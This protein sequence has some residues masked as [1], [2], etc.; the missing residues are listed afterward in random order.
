MKNV[1]TYLLLT[2]LAMVTLVPFAYLICAALKIHMFAALFLP[3][4]HEEAH[5]LDDEESAAT[6]VVVH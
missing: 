4:K 1:V 5:L 2:I 6:P 3:R